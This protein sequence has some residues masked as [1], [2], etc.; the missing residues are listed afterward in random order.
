M[1]ESDMQARVAHAITKFPLFYREKKSKRSLLPPWRKSLLERG[2][3]SLK[4]RT[5]CPCS[6]KNEFQEIT[7]SSDMIN[8]SHLGATLET[9]GRNYRRRIA[10]PSQG[11]FIFPRILFEHC[12]Y[13]R[14]WR[15]VADL[16]TVCLSTVS[17]EPHICGGPCAGRWRP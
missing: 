9:W 15:R 17:L 14:I 12:Y 6:F 5:F 4:V 2:C 16:Q 3:S 10:S 13:L 8:P 7:S 11:A 1:V